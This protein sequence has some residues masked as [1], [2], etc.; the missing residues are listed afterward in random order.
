MKSIAIHHFPLI[1]P[2][3]GEKY[4]YNPVLKKRFKNRPEER[5]RLRW[6]EYLL[7]QTEWP[8]SRIGFEAPVSLPQEEN[9]LRADLVLYNRDFSPRHPGGV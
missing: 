8:K 7:H 4:L 5:V 9:T 3:P 1:I 2:Q 6:V